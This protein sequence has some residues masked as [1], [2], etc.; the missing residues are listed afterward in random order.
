MI[1]TV[2]AFIFIDNLDAFTID[3]YA[4]IHQTQ[5][6]H[7]KTTSRSGTLIHMS[8]ASNIKEIRTISG[9]HGAKDF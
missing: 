5:T 2:S 6:Q 1:M 4:F 3:Q 8:F 9:L 7:G